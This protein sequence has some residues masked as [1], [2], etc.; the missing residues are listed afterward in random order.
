MR[1]GATVQEAN[2]TVIDTLINHE[3]LQVLL[4]AEVVTTALDV[5]TATARTVPVDEGTLK[6]SYHVHHTK[7]SAQN[8]FP[9]PTPPDKMT[10][11]VG[12]VLEYAPTI[13]ARGGKQAFGKGAFIDAYQQNV[14]G[15]ALRIANIVKKYVNGE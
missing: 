10:A 13:E 2:N 1:V 4:D 6:N 14:D 9:L 15:F 12:S 3:D 5:M 8:E 7:H 11:V